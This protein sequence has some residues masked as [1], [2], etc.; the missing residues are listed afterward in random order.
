MDPV[1]AKAREIEALEMTA[2]AIKA[3][4]GDREADRAKLAQ[5]EARLDRLIALLEPRAEAQPK[6]E[7][8]KADPKGK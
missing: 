7:P 4:K 5:I 2:T 6:P 1:R 8:P 3:I